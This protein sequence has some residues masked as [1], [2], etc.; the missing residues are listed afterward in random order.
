MGRQGSQKVTPYKKC[1]SLQSQFVSPGRTCSNLHEYLQETENKI[2]CP[3]RN[4]LAQNTG[5]KESP[6][7]LKL[8]KPLW[9][10]EISPLHASHV[11]EKEENQKWNG[12]LCYYLAFHSLGVA[13]NSGLVKYNLLW[14]LKGSLHF[15]FISFSHRR[16]TLP[17]APFE[18]IT[19]F[20]ILLSG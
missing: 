3:R 4:R 2:W 17:W 15:H 1:V 12:L 11:G 20:L 18:Y 9:N 13:K 10:S 5:G 6:F 8:A 19:L 7:Q 14:G 16:G